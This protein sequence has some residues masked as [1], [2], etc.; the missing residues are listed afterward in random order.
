MPSPKQ[1]KV[2]IVGSRSVGE[3]S[4]V[5]LSHCPARLS[6]LCLRQ[7]A[8]WLTWEDDQ[9]SRLWRKMIKYKGQDFSTEIVDTAGQDEY[10]I[11]NSKHFIGIHGYMLVY[12]V[13]SLP[14]FEMVQVIREKILNHLWNVVTQGTESVPIVIVGN[15]SDLRPEQRQVTPEDGQKVAEK[16]QCGWTEASA[17]YNEN[18]SKA[19]ELLIGQIEKSQN[20]GE[21]PAKSNCNLICALIPTDASAV[22]MLGAWPDSANPAIGALQAALY[23]I[24]IKCGIRKSQYGNSGLVLVLLEDAHHYYRDIS[25]YRPPPSLMSD[26]ETTSDCPFCGFKPTEGEYELLLHI[27]TRHPDGQSPFAVVEDPVPCPKDSCG[28]YVAPDELA[29]HLE[30]H[31]LEA[32]EATPEPTEPPYVPPKPDLQKPEERES[33]SSSRGKHRSEK[34]GSTIQAWR[35]LFAGRHSRESSSSRARH[36]TKRPVAEGAGVSKSTDRRP[37][38]RSGASQQTQGERSRQFARLGTSELG[39]F[40]NEK[41]MP[42]WLVELLKNE[43]QVVN[44]GVLPVLRQLLEQRGFCGYRNIQMLT[45]HIIGAQTAGAERFGRTFPSIF[46][47]QDL[48]ENAWDMG[49]NTQGRVE[50]GGVKGTRKY[51][52]TPEAQAVFLSLG[53]TCSVQAFKDKERGRSKTHLL[54]AIEQYFQ[55]GV[56]NVEDRIHLTGLP[57]V[58]LQHPGHS[59]TIVGYEKEMDGHVNLLV[60]DPSFHDSTKIRSLVGKAFRHKPSSIDESLQPYR[61]GSHYLRKYNQFEVLYL[62]DY[63]AVS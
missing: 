20:P 16:I 55:A 29:Y 62:T 6:L 13:S 30:L 56:T 36:K 48:I 9:A 51:I 46:Q 49:I 41:K 60:F 24:S 25:T 58:Y 53:I 45:S 5:M 17:R 63:A 43:G 52:G 4:L 61:R 28:E 26:S 1:R 8:D 50:T 11:L 44:D 21:A 40:A 39:R 42:S 31:N 2:A 47:I 57:P 59:L 54:E 7:K 35:D 19:F 23:R 32:Q 14:S 33:R 3:S 38:S 27:E 15:K 22:V 10:S 34:K 12:S 37:S 18:V